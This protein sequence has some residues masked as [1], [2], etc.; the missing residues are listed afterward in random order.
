MAI[1]GEELQGF[2]INQINARQILHGSGAGNDIA[3]TRTDQQ[4][5]L[6]IF[7]VLRKFPHHFHVRNKCAQKNNFYLLMAY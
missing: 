5:N 4:L 6:L 7:F 3:N 2:V 1:I